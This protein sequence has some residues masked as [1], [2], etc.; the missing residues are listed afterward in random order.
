VS[1]RN[2]K[3]F[4]WPSQ[5][6]MG[7]E[8][9][10]DPRTVR[11]NLEELVDAGQIRIVRTLRGNRY[12]FPEPAPDRTKMSD[13]DRTKMS[14]ADRTKMSDAD[15]TKMSDADRTKMSDRSSEIFK[16]DFRKDFEKDSSSSNDA[17]AAELFPPI[18]LQQAIQELRG[19]GFSQTQAEQYADKDAHLVLVAIPFLRMRFQDQ[20]KRAIRSR[21]AFAR[22]LL[23]NPD[24]YGF[25]KMS[26]GRWQSPPPE[27]SALQEREEQC[28]A[29][30]K[31]A[32]EARAAEAAEQ[33]KRTKKDREW[34]ERWEAT[35][36]ERRAEIEAIVASRPEWKNNF[37][38]RQRLFRICCINEFH[39]Q[40][41]P[42]TF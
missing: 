33:E 20:A 22:G 8:I 28:Q 11:R 6:R 24:N 12:Y 7:R 39:C 25:E 15:R 38:G 35:T 34:E 37:W 42:S 32:A 23:N 9:G 36:P 19:F 26:D 41:D 10:R 4:A 18:E 21:V 40:E 27:K 1:L 3:R 29:K 30:K 5:E 13:A 17:A 31:R 16:K 2:G 14:D